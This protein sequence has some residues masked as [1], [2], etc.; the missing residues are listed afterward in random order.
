MHS[1]HCTPDWWLPA[2]TS[3]FEMVSEMKISDVSPKIMLLAVLTPEIN[4]NPRVLLWP[5]SHM[6]RDECFVVQ[7]SWAEL[8]RKWSMLGGNEGLTADQVYITGGQ[9]PLHTGQEGNK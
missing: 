6:L 5:A 7:Q 4:Q 8:C 9:L 2:T 1:L 3:L